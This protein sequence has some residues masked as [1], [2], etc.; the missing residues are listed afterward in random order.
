M[1]NSAMADVHVRAAT[2]KDLAAVEDLLRQSD[3]PLDGV[4]ESLA[5]FVVA[6]REGKIVGVAGLEE[7]GDYGLLRSAAVTPEWRGRGLGRTL[8][9][10][11]IANAESSGLR[12]LYLLTTTAE[13][14]FPTFGFR[15]TTRDGV[16]LAVQA[17][18]E[19]TDAC[20]SSA[21]VMKLALGTRPGSVQQQ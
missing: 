3:L 20:P 10:R 15:E 16:P 2:A 6:E 18:A 13:K 7:C 1:T 8:V 17:T 21:T 12:A 4:S 9:E 19:F 5:S 14:Y 11:V